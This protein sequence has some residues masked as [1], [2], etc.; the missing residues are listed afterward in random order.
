LGLVLVAFATNGCG[1]LADLKRSFGK[2]VNISLNLISKNLLCGKNR[3]Y[4]YR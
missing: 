4:K 1:N 3:F 2:M